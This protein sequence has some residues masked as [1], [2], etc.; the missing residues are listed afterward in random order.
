M[1][2]NLGLSV[3]LILLMIVIALLD[4]VLL[5]RNCGTLAERRRVKLQALLQAIC[6][7]L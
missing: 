6:L 3:A 7:A 5:H 4:W 1:V 2:G